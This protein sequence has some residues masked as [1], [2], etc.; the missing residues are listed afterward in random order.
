[1]SSLLDLYRDLSK[2]LSFLQAVKAQ[3]HGSSDIRQVLVY[4]Y[5]DILEFHVKAME[6]FEKGS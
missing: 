1:M 4:I 2:Q 3:M 5:K 6:F